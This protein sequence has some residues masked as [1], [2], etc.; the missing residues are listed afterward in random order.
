M[1]QPGTQ[2]D[3]IVSTSTPAGAAGPAK[4]VARA[5]WRDFARLSR[6]RHWVKNVFVFMPVPFALATGARL[7]PVSFLLGLAGFCLANS[8][9]YALNDARDAERDRLHP[10]KRERPVASGRISTTGA[11]LWSAFLLAGGV[12]LSL[13][14]RHPGAVG[15]LLVYAGLNLLYSLGGK[16]V[17]LLDVF[18][19]SSGFVLR[20]ILGCVLVDVDPS[21]WLLLCSST[22]ALFLALAKRRG[23]LVQGMDEAHRPSLGGYNMPFLDHAMTIMA[24]MTLIAYALYTIEA[25]VLIPGREFAT[26]PFAVF[27]VLEYLRLAQVRGEGGSPVDSL[28]ASPVI[29]LCGLG[30]VAATL[31]SVP[32]PW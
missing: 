15:V 18:L 31:W 24:A 10:E 8:A 25:E 14:S 30:W 22:L 17:P 28:L 20:V 11:F 16:N 19:L 32:L 5:R 6:P 7:E 12:A 23:D 29:L 26:L 4:P 27:G 13:A 3:A 9:V 2:G 1:P 21:N